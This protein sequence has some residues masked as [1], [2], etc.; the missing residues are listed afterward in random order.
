[1]SLKTSTLRPEGLIRGLKF[2]G[3]T[4]PE[5]VAYEVS[6]KVSQARLACQLKQAVRA[7]EFIDYRRAAV[8]RS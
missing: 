5:G 8:F 3:L 7:V 4:C 2:I 6:E 1:M